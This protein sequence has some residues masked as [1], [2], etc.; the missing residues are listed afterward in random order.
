VVAAIAEA[1]PT[2]DIGSEVTR[3]QARFAGP[4]PPRSTTTA[5]LAL[6][7]RRI[8]SGTILLGFG[9]SPETSGLS[10][11]VIASQLGSSPHSAKPLGSSSSL[12][13]VVVVVIIKWPD[14]DCFELM[15]LC[16]LSTLP[17]AGPLTTFL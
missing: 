5:A 9:P 14:P 6:W 7:W 3:S 2:S 16:T 15:V 10:K 4:T 13:V 12:L 17:F 11:V 1:R 8:A